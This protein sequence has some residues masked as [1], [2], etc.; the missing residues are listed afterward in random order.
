MSESTVLGLSLAGIAVEYPDPR[1]SRRVLSD[2]DLEVMPGQLIAISG[3]SGSGKTSLLRIAYGQLD[4]TAGSVTWQG[5]AVADLDER[6]RQRIRREK[7]GYAS[8]DALVLEDQSVLANAQLGGA[9]RAEAV[10][11]LELLGLG[12]MTRRK[13]RGLSG[14]ERQRL[15]VVRALAKL[16]EIAVMDEPTAALDTD[17]AQVV[18]DVLVAAAERGAAVLVASHDEVILDAVDRTYRL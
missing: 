15:T 10:E 8:Q 13:A 2:F 3:R 9:G 1:G 6:E 11:F 4:P 16:P 14:G 5:R 18:R 12:A 17:A 7:F